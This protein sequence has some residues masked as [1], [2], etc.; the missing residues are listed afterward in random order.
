MADNV[1]RFNFAAGRDAAEKIRLEWSL[2]GLCFTGLGVRLL[3]LDSP[4]QPP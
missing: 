4:P 1:K 2:L 3:A